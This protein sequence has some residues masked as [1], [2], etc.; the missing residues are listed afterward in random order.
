M[1]GDLSISCQE[2]F[3]WAS[4]PWKARPESTQITAK[5]ISYH[6][7]HHEDA[8]EYLLGRLRLS[9]KPQNERPQFWLVARLPAPASSTYV[10]NGQPN[11]QPSTGWSLRR[12]PRIAV[13]EH[14][15]VRSS[16]VSIRFAMTLA[17]RPN[18]SLI[19][20]VA[21]GKAVLRPKPS[22]RMQADT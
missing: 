5:L 2:L 10:F 8:K 7:E 12:L 22:F 1:H 13:L 18:H 19:P 21:P 15:G 17:V 9:A 4:L 3:L 20:L 6:A 16:L 11:K 14:A